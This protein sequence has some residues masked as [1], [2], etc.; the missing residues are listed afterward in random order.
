M[1]GHILQCQ[2]A[3]NVFIYLV[4]CLFPMLC[5]IIFFPVVF[6]VST[7]STLGFTGTTGST[8]T[9]YGIEKNWFMLLARSR[10]KALEYESEIKQKLKKES[11]WRIFT[12][13]KVLNCSG[14]SRGKSS[15]VL[16]LAKMCL[17]QFLRRAYVSTVFKL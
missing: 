5:I 6:L 16:K 4:M 12:N 1:A 3:I 17:L 9:P 13:C 10:K 7:R 8:A 2:P 15:D 14:Y 11:K